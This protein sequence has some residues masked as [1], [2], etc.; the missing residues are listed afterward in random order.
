MIRARSTVASRR[1][2]N[3]CFHGVGAPKRPLE[4]GEGQYWITVEQFDEILSV[5]AA[6]PQIRLSF[7]DGN[8]SDVAIV[9]PRLKDMG[10]VAEF[11]VVAGR[12]GEEGSVDSSDLRSLI[13]SGMIVGSHGMH[14][15]PWRFLDD[16]ALHEELTVAA[17]M[18]RAA[19]EAPVRRAACPLG[20]YDRRVLS[21]LR[22]RN[23][24]RVYTVDG[25]G[26]R[27]DAWLQARQSIR[28]SDNGESVLRLLNDVN[29]RGVRRGLRDT[30]SLVKRVR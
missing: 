3:L 24:A 15:R 6:E 30:K 29:S 26:A 2:L 5:I 14:H 4:D 17:A 9:L 10:V 8:K 19:A 22:Q 7:D 13:D 1:V 12:I 21:A 16:E 23:Y 25:G 20:S 11:Y 27:A 28:S 18:I